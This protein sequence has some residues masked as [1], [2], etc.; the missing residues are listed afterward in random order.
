[1]ITTTDNA[2][3]I[4]KA[5]CTELP[6]FA[7]TLQIGVTAGLDLPA[8]SGVTACFKKVVTFF[9]KNHE[10]QTALRAKRSTYGLPEHKLI[11]DVTTRWNSTFETIQ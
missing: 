3:N 5:V 10:A 4:V 2:R 9:W 6:C 8:V 1:M 11:Q 7:H